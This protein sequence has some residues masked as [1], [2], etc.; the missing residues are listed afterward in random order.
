MQKLGYR[1][2]VVYEINIDGIDFEFKTAAIAKESGFNGRYIEEHPY[3]LK[4]KKSN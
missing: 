2:F 3:C 1:N 4:R